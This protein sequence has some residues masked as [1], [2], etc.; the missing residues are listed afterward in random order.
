[1]ARFSSLF[2][3]LIIRRR[4]CSARSLQAIWYDDQEANGPPNRSATWLSAR[5]QRSGTRLARTLKID[6]RGG[7]Q[8]EQIA[9]A[10]GV[11]I[12]EGVDD[13]QANLEG[14]MSVPRHL[15][16]KGP[17]GCVKPT[18]SRVGCSAE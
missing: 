9:A 3:F 14:E 6:G 10:V 4:L 16:T 8:S 13:E 12:Y 15:S 7:D 1:M 11:A 5:R 2:W 17:G 18:D